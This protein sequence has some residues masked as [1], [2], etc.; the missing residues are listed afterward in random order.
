MKIR[1]LNRRPEEIVARSME[2]RNEKK[3]RRKKKKDISR[4]I[5]GEYARPEELM[6]FHH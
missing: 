4:K 5:K 3:K 1:R 6:D 2:E